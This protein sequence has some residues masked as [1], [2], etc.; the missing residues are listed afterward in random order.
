[1]DAS[2]YAFA[3]GLQATRATLRVWQRHP[4]RVVGRW[5]L[6]SSV[7]A[8]GLLLA[9]WLVASL[10][11]GYQQTLTLQPPFAVG[12]AGEV[13]HVLR[14]NLLVLALHAM[15]CVAGFMAGSSLPLQAEHHRG[16]SRWV[17]E[18]GGRFAIAFVVGATAFS[19]S[20][21]AY[22]IGHT[23]A[24]VSHFLR[25]SPALLLLGVLP[26]AIPELVALFLPLAAWIIASRRGD[27]DQLLA[28]TF[29][30]VALAVPMLVAA[31]CIEVYVSP[32]LF[33]ALTGIHPPIV[34]ESDG[35]LVTIG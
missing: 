9:V 34:R 31:A 10:D 7:A 35:W 23:L 22:V 2:A 1:M 16:L 5:L 21:Q 13:L 30:T 11:H 25:V 32:R 6:G 3:Q 17:H 29:V 19:L 15:A 12:D 26:H 4:L 28:A 24:G 8:A 18:H 27:W 20:A 14:S 33:T